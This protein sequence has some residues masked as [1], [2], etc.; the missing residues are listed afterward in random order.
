MNVERL[1]VECG[2][3]LGEMGFCCFC[4]QKK[5]TI[6]KGKGKVVNVLLY[7]LENMCVSTCPRR[8]ENGCG[9]PENEFWASL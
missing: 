1:H 7:R 4:G 8:P 6:R 2:S 3:H 5:K 9:P